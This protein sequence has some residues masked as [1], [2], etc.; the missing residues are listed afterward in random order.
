MTQ[1]G[2]ERVSWIAALR[3]IA[4]VSSAVA[5]FEQRCGALRAYVFPFLLR[6]DERRLAA[7]T[8]TVMSAR[9]TITTE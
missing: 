8:M 5:G 1:M 3:T 7:E 9:E 2:A 4:I 6:F